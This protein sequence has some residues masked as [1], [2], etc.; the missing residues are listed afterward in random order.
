MNCLI[1]LHCTILIKSI[2][3]HYITLH[4]TNKQKMETMRSTTDMPMMV[5]NMSMNMSMDAEEFEMIFEKPD[6]DTTTSSTRTFTT[7]ESEVQDQFF[8]QSFSSSSSFE[9]IQ[10]LS[11]WQQEEDNNDVTM[12]LQLDEDDDDEGLLA[13]PDQDPED[14]QLS[15]NYNTPPGYFFEDAD[16]VDAVDNFSFLDRLAADAAQADE[17][18]KKQDS[19]FTN[20]SPLP[21]QGLDEV[22]QESL[23]NLIQSMK[24]SQETREC[25]SMKTVKTEKYSRCAS[26]S[27]VLGSIELSSRQIDSYLQTLHRAVL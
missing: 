27:Q 1:E 26:V 6:M 25:L 14:D 16:A 24:R 5:M 15:S 21:P 11:V 23:E 19:S 13:L 18:A 7:M 17:E 9:A 22:L 4:N 3:P 12:S 2:H 10:M 8:N 20:D